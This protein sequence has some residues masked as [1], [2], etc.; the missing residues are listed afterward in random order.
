MAN[1][2]VPSLQFI[3]EKN[4]VP[5]AI[6]LRSMVETTAIL[7]CF[8]KELIEANKRGNANRLFHF[9]NKTLL[10]RSGFNGWNVYNHAI[11]KLITQVANDYE[12]FDS[13]YDNLSGIA[14][15][16]YDGLLDAYGTITENPPLL[17]L[18]NFA[19]ERKSRIYFDSFIPTVKLFI[20]TYTDII[21]DIKRFADLCEKNILD[22]MNAKSKG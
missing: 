13:H 19:L 9:M 5:G 6:L 11:G 1:L 21:E 8:Y 14:H 7:Y 15:P 20:K 3:K 17:N 12:Y 10:G 16:T 4:L 18:G 22:K 2:A